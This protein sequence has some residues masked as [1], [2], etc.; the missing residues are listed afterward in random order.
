M[1]KIFYLLSICA[2]ALVSCNKEEAFKLEQTADGQYVYRFTVNNGHAAWK[3]GDQVAVYQEDGTIL[4]LA[5]LSSSS[6]GQTSGAFSL[7]VEP[8]L[9]DGTKLVFKY[10]YVED[11]DAKTGKIADKQTSLVGGAGAGANGLATADVTFAQQNLV[12]NL[13]PIHAYVKLNVSSSAFADYNLDGATF[14]AAESQLAGNITYVRDTVVAKD[15]MTIT[16]TSDYVKTTIAEPAAVGSGVNGL[17]LAALPADLT[18]KT[19]WAIVHMSKGIET[20]TLPVQITEPVVLQAGA[21]KEIELANL[22]TASAPSW[23]QPVETRYVAAYGD[24]W[25]YGPENTVLFTEDGQ[26]KVV[27]L[28]ARGNFMMVKKPAKV[29]INNVSDQNGAVADRV[30]IN[31]VDGNNKTSVDLDANCSVKVKMKVNSSAGY[32]SSMLVQDEAGKT[33]WGINLWLSHDGVNTAAYNDGAVMDRN[34]GSSKVSS[35]KKHYTCNGV[36]FQWGRPFGF[37]W[38]TSNKGTTHAPTASTNTLQTSAENPFTM[39][40]YDNG[41]N[42][43]GFPWDW[44]WG[45]GSN[46]NRE[47]D[48]D[49]LWGNPNENAP[50]RTNSGKKSIFDPC[51]KGYRVVSADI[52][53]E[54]NE[55]I[56][57][58]LA[59]TTFTSTGPAVVYTDNTTHHYI[60]YKGISWGFHGL[61]APNTGMQKIGD[62]KTG[63]IAFWSNANHDANG[64]QL[65]FRINGEK[66]ERVQKRVKNAATPIRCMVD[67][68]NR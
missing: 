20:V 47:G 34:I 60:V 57:G 2:L 42:G 25:S 37:P 38:S 14:W 58:E 5:E 43:D 61:F 65:Y 68:E 28:K 8:L 59:G 44:I 12:V 3:A 23:Y 51:P 24:G 33:I 46:K 67:T 29:K 36:Y 15:V 22:T 21:V 56:Q 53:E 17:M 10:P 7:T 11:A 52:I 1:K 45:D 16:K 18:G 13:A 63:A 27:E 31:D 9:A 41:G 30:Y 6:V 66:L 40:R 49:D 26:E 19:V 48:L 64:H 32:C 39:F 62:A 54:L 4:G 35:E 55:N 50:I